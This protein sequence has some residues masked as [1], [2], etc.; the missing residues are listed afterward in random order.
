LHLRGI[1]KVV[2]EPMPLS[3][4]RQKSDNAAPA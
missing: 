1:D 4:V 2:F 3:G